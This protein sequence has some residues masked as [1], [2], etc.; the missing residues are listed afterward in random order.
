LPRVAR[1]L[2]WTEIRSGVF[3][4]CWY[5]PPADPKAKGR[6]ERLSLRTRDAAEAQ[7]RFSAFLAQGEGIFAPKIVHNEIDVALALQQYFTEHV[8]PNVVDAVRQENAIRHLKVFFEGS[9][10]SSIDIPTCRGYAEARRSG[11]IGGGARRK[12]DRAKGSNS[13]I[14]RELNVLQAAARHALRWKRITADRMPTFEL[15]AE[16][17]VVEEVMWLTKAE[18]R[19]LIAKAEGD[20]RLFILLAYWTGSRRAA[21]ETLRL[22]QINLELNRINLAKPGERKTKKRRPMVPLFWRLRPF[23]RA[24]VAAAKA[25]GRQTIFRANIDFHKRFATLCKALGY[26]ERSFPHILR[27]SRATHMLMAGESIYKV[28]RLLGD[29]VKTI[30]NRYGH[31]SVEFLEGRG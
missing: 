18:V 6:T 5:R 7:T 4:V 31:A 16:D 23:V 19:K 11:A 28:A 29:T 10:L 14:R 21:I 13:T 9:P 30:E 22:D 15:P 12:G 24:A 8:R 17:E 1:E 25:E 2:P 27:H 26:G 3:Y 20:L